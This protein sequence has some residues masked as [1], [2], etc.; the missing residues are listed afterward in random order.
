MDIQR[1]TNDWTDNRYASYRNPTLI[2][3]LLKGR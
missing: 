2:S 1:A 3:L